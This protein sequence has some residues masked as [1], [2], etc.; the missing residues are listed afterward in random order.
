MN[1]STINWRYLKIIS[2]PLAGFAALL[3]SSWIARGHIVGNQRM[4]LLTPSTAYILSLA[5]AFLFWLAAMEHSGGWIRE[6]FSLP[7]CLLSMAGFIAAAEIHQHFITI[8]ASVLATLMGL[9]VFADARECLKRTIADPR[10]AFAAEFAGFSSA[11]YRMAIVLLWP[12]I[13]HATGWMIYHLLDITG[14][15]VGAKTVSNGV[16]VVSPYFSIRVNT[17]CSGLEGIF[18]FYFLI[19]GVLL[20]DWQLFKKWR[21]VELYMTGFIFMFVINAL[22]IVSFFSVGYWANKPDA[23]PFMSSL[24]DAP[25]QL[26]HTYVGWVYYFMGFIIFAGCCYRMAA[27]EKS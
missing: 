9:F 18:L 26:F 24:K 1:V 13:K 22:R 5:P 14:M 7:F 6:R 3:I 16:M 4:L 21:L 11:F 2:V 20:L 10:A 15:S 17:S 23:G 12:R 25:L 27:R 19:T 8:F